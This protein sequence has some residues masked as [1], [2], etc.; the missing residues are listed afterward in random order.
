ML[1]PKYPVDERADIDASTADAAARL[2]SRV[3]A[4]LSC[5]EAEQLLDGN[6]R[7][8]DEMCKT[9]RQA[10]E[11][12]VRLDC[13]LGEVDRP[14]EDRNQWLH[15]LRAE[16]EDVEHS[17]AAV[18][19]ELLLAKLEVQT[20]CA[21]TGLVKAARLAEVL[22][23]NLDLRRRCHSLG[24]KL[25][26]LVSTTRSELRRCGERPDTHPDALDSSMVKRW[27]VEFEAAR[28]ANTKVLRALRHPDA[29]ESLPASALEEVIDQDWRFLLE[30]V[31]LFEKVKAQYSEQAETGKEAEEDD[32]GVE[33]RAC[34]AAGAENL[35]IKIEER[36][37]ALLECK[38]LVQEAA[39][40]G[41]QPDLDL[42]EKNI[43]AA[44]ESQ[45]GAWKF[46]T[47]HNIDLSKI[48]ATKFAEEMLPHPAAFGT[49]TADAA[50]DGE[51]YYPPVIRMLTYNIFIRAPAPGFAHNTGDDRKDERLTRFA[52]RHLGCYDVVCLQEMFGAFSQR[53]EWL[54]GVA[55][56][57]GFHDSHYSSIS[58]RPRFI[59]D[60]GLLILSRLPMVSRAS[61]TY[62]AG[63]HLDRLSAK[64]ALL[65]T[66]RCGQT[67][68]LLHVCTTHLQ[69]TYSEES[70]LQ[71]SSVRHQQLAQLVGFLQEQTRDI[72]RSG[73]R[74]RGWPL[75][76]CGTLN[77]NGRQSATQGSH[78]DEYCAVVEYL[79]SELGEVRDLL[80]D[81]L[82]SHPVTYADTRIT[83]AGEMPSERVLTNA[84]VYTTPGFKRK[85][86]DYMFFFPPEPPGESLEDPGLTASSH[87][88]ENDAPLSQIRRGPPTEPVVPAT[89]QVEKFLV[90]R[91]K[92]VG[93]P[94]TQLSDHYGVEATLAVVSETCGL[95]D[96]GVTPESAFCNEPKEGE[97]RRRGEEGE[98][99]GK[100][101]REG[102]GE[103]EEGDEEE[104]DPFLL[105]CES[106]TGYNTVDTPGKQFVPPP[107][108]CNDTRI[109]VDAA[110]EAARASNNGVHRDL[111]VVATSNV[112]DTQELLP[113]PD[114][115]NDTIIALDAA[116]E[117][118]RVLSNGVLGDLQAVETPAVYAD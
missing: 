113:P 96:A 32:M 21:S 67:G 25:E 22:E 9:L 41:V 46:L 76:L 69:S 40:R 5:K 24:M 103:V 15:S 108:C 37:P 30:L 4:S 99:E 14:W 59:M 82:G 66:L 61:L 107:E 39:A 78:S 43:A 27:R 72:T 10:W 117:A 109:A 64:G 83:A 112:V 94:I 29:A 34:V 116:T 92:D 80:Y 98:G 35:R 16:Y 13:Q 100:G 70:A 36:L 86:L 12:T 51:H 106:K 87:G 60:G 105:S 54:V 56:R 50:A 62:D 71:S 95:H 38:L 118:A 73:V 20:A 89:C 11:C 57:L 48:V 104:D 84:S 3:L 102:E 52:E 114:C 88:A 7:I 81:I 33:A 47:G 68:P 6:F 19:G 28:D 8:N 58:V 74:R 93:A 42:A 53:R 90:D 26:V 111:Q 45:A 49:A 77:F 2:R 31:G 63:A 75:L 97:E 44:Q 110:S 79:R 101:E 115:L 18:E 55:D 23:A 1:P 65:A 91:A 85:C 17:K